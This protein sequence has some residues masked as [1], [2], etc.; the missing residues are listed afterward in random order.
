MGKSADLG[1]TNGSTATIEEHAS[2]LAVG[3]M[4]IF[5]ASAVCLPTGL[6]TA[7]FLTRQ[8]GPVD[9]GLLTVTATIIV[10]IEGTLTV[11][12]SRSA[13][14]CIAKAKDWKAVSAKFLQVQLLLGLGATAVLVA[15]A[16]LLSSHQMTYYLRI[17]A[18]SRYN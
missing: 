16:P 14:T 1:A 17:Y 9:Y 5:L 7:A 10:W 12:F 3:T 13:I 18:T 4:Q 11:G 6:L 8:L 15:V 2:H